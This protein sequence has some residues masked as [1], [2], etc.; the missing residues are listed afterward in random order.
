M[1]RLDA[2]E[3]CHSGK[4]SEPNLQKPLTRLRGLSLVAIP[5]WA[6]VLHD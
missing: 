4:P 2:K 6:F 5:P 3:D 1:P